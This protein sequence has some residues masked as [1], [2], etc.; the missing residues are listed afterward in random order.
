MSSIT[1]LQRKQK[2]FLVTAVEKLSSILHRP[3]LREIW[4]A[5]KEGLFFLTHPIL[6]HRISR[7]RGRRTREN[8]VIHQIIVWLDAK[9]AEHQITAR[10]DGR[11]KRV[12]SIHRKMGRRGT[13]LEAVHDLRGV[14]IIVADRA[15][16]YQVLAL[17]H[18][19]Y[20][21]IPGQLDDYI[22]NPKGNG[23]QSL[24]TVVVDDRGKRFEVQIRTPVMHQ[25]AE[26][27][28]AAHWRYKD[29]KLRTNP[30]SGEVSPSFRSMPVDLGIKATSEE[31]V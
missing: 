12:S 13:P 8:L 27:G 14:R 19:S 31:P 7:A 15:T 20:D 24:H 22:A 17:V 9:L 5:L 16:C 26:R 28:S 1:T 21:P 25:V 18:E 29:R 23:Y 11:L 30:G 3:G 10:F 4:G 6:Y 2:R